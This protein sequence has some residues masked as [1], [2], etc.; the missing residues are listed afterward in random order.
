MSVFT[1]IVAP[2]LIGLVVGVMSGLLGIGGGTV[3]VP[4]FRLLFGLDPVA[5]TATSLFTIIPTSISGAITHLRNKTCLLKLGVAAGI[6]GACTSPVGVWL[7][8]RAPAWTVMVAVAIVISFSSYKMFRKAF[9]IPKGG[10][11]D[12]PTKNGL[13]AEEER[14]ELSNKQLVQGFFIGLIAGLI[15]GFVGVG[16]GFIMVPMFISILGLSMKKISGTSLIAVLILAIPGTITNACL[17]NIDFAAGIFMVC[18][19]I[20][21]AAIGAKFITRVPERTLR[22]L[23]GCFQLLLA[24]SL[25]AKEFGILG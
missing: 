6:G 8:N 11:T 19:T 7:S 2:V 13:S 3:M 5:A 12:A 22:L 4:V 10:K 18:G 25:V 1:T 20:P 9:D 17:G 15:A 14:F 16:G 24:I 23:F 21:G